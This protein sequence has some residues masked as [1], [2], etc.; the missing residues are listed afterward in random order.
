[1]IRLARPHIDESTIDEVGRVLRSGNLVQGLKVKVF[2]EKLQK[3]P[4]KSVNL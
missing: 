2:E 4:K 3:A 1:M